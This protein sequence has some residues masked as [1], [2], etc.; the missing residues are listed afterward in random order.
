M[1]ADDVAPSVR[2]QIRGGVVRRPT[3]PASQ[4]IHSFLRHLRSERETGA[5][6]PI[7]ADGAHERLHH[8]DGRSGRAGWFAQRTVTALQ[9]GARLLRRLRDTSVGWAPP[10]DAIFNA[11]AV[12]GPEL[13]Y[14]HGEPGPWNFVW[15]NGVAVG[16]IDREFL[17]PAPR[18][19]DVAFAL[20]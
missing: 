4:T 5:P 17:H 3:T 11:A 19:S 15:H 1:K 10:P 6:A 8:I 7:D 12:D 13:V 16:L 9:S 14:C 18:V 2:V 20:L